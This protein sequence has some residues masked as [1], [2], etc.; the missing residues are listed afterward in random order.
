MGNDSGLPLLH[1]GRV[2]DNDLGSGE[3]PSPHRPGKFLTLSD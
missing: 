1:V 3:R 2:R